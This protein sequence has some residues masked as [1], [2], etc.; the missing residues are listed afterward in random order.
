MEK[1]EEAVEKAEGEGAS[2]PARPR[3]LPRIG[4]RTPS[5]LFKG[6][7]SPLSSSTIKGAIFDEGENDV[8]GVG[9]YRALFPNLIQSWRYAWG[10]GD[11]PFYHGQLPP[12]D[13]GSSK[14]ALFRVVQMKS[15]SMKNGGIAV[16]LDVGGFKESHPKNKKDVGERLAL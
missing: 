6:I 7:I 5:A 10:L 2:L 15:L 8:S 9:W 4:A 16:T 3:G 11:F 12:Y 14:N 1:W 13:Y